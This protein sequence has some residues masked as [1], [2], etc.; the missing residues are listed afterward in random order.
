[1]LTAA[2]LAAVN[3][4]GLGIRIIANFDPRP[5][6]WEPLTTHIHILYHIISLKF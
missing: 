3:I 4:L 2:I 1:M 6:F 5:F